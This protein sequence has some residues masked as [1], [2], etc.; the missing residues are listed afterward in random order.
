MG[1]IKSLTKPSTTQRQDHLFRSDGLQNRIL[2]FDQ[3][4]VIALNFYIN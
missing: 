1:K 3:R 2:S 4:R